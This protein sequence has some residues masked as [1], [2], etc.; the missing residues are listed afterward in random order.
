MWALA[1]GSGAAGAGDGPPPIV[2]PAAETEGSSPLAPSTV[3]GVERVPPRTPDALEQ[4][5]AALSAEVRELVT[6][7][8]AA[9]RYDCCVQHSCKLCAMRAGGCKCGEAA[10][11]GAPVCEECAEMWMRGQGAEPVDP[12]TI[13]SFLEAERAMRG[14]YGEICGKARL[15]QATD[16]ASGVAAPK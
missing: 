5:R 16:G 2:E 14:D 12:K 15:E 8:E 1:C 13:H 10:R 11:Q 7:L 4:R 3:D 6:E 9:G